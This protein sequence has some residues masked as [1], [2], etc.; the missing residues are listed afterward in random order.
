MSQIDSISEKL[1]HQAVE[2]FSRGRTTLV[3]AHRF[4]TVLFADRIVVMDGGRVIDVGEHDQLLSR[5]RLYH[6][7]YNTQFAATEGSA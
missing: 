5:C 1:I 7:L 3:N 6:H 4:A 2:E